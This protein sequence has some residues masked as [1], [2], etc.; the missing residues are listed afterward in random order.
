[1]T[2][3][4]PVVCFGAGN[5]GRRVA[6]AVHPV[7]F[8]DNKSSLWGT[9]V[10]CIPV[11]SPKAAVEHYPDATFVVSIWHPSRIDTMETRVNQLKLLGASNVIPFWSLFAEHPNLLPNL[12]WAL[13]DFY[14][15]HG[16]EIQQGRALLDSEGKVEFDR[17]MKLR[18]EHWSD[19]VIA[20]GAQYF[21]DDLVQLSHN[22]VFV[23]CGAYDG[24]TI[25]EFRRASNDQFDRIIAFEPDPDNFSALRS[26]AS[27]DSRIT[28]HPYAVGARRETLHFEVGGTGARVSSDGA[29]EVQAISLDEAL[30]GLAPTYI[31]F[32][33]EGSEPDA[34]QGAWKTIT[35]HRPKLAVC[36]YHL[37]DHLWKMPTMLNKLQPNSLLTLRA[38]CADGFDCVCYCIPR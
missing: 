23:D 21:P 25:S 9:A 36:A 34:L 4:S 27:G 31:K 29:C 14:A 38:H 18:L 30:D 16:D 2:H 8:C 3:S 10:D 24:D 6:R 5:L 12:F 37:P 20:A 7:L 32:D 22:E 1:M 35:T 15:A 26:A 13:P 28:V 17:Q 19:Q 11:D 33:I